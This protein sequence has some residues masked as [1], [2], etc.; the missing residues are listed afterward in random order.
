MAENFIKKEKVIQLFKRG[1][2]ELISVFVA[3]MLALWVDDWHEEKQRKQKIELAMSAVAAELEVNYQALKKAH[4]FQSESLKIIRDSAKEAGQLTNEQAAEIMTRMYSR[5]M[6]QPA[7]LLDTA[8]RVLVQ[9]QLLHYMDHDTVLKY[10]SH[11]RQL[12]DLRERQEVHMRSMNDYRIHADEDVKL[13]QLYYHTV[14]EMWWGEK[15][16]LRSFEGLDLAFIEK[17]ADKQLTD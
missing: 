1:A 5:S 8:W 11:Y 9:S 3:I 17:A 16:M 14:N 2:I 15:N 6:F 13:L 4:D 10:E 12:Q 7:Q